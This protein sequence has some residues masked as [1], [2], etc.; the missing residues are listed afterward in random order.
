MILPLCFWT[1]EE[2]KDIPSEDILCE[3]ADATFYS[4]SPQ[5][6]AY[7]RLLND[8]LKNRY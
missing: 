2:L 5:V 4:S 7:I 1:E 3:L 6:D 8:E